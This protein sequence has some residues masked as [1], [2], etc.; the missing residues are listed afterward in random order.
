M[1][2]LNSE[3]FI[4]QL[5]WLI[6][7]FVFLFIFLW[8]ISLPRIGSVLKKRENRINDDIKTAK[9]LQTEAEKIQLDIDNKLQEAK[10]QNDEI[11]KKSS[12]EFQDYS[13]KE[14]ERVDNEL[15][16][17]MEKSAALIE[18]NKTESIKQIH[19]QIYAITKLTLSKISNIKVTDQEVKEIVDNIKKKAVH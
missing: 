1:P 15:A 4:S 12:Q 7:T 2:Q 19:A 14:L 9:Q 17:Q 8:K 13:L 6:L 16:N 10:S 5:F 3:F 11:L 18:K